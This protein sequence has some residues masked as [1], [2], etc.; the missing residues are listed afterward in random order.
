MATSSTSSTTTKKYVLY[1]YENGKW[2]K[3]A[4]SVSIGE[5]FWIAKTEAANWVRSFTIGM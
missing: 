2:S 3:G 5:S 4:P 1:P